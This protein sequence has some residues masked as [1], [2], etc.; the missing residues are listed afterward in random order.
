MWTRA[1]SCNTEQDR[2]GPLPTFRVSQDSCW[3]WG[4]GRQTYGSHS[5]FRQ[6]LPKPGLFTRTS[7]SVASSSLS[8]WS[9]LD[10]VRGAFTGCTCDWG[11]GMQ[12]PTC[13]STHVYGVGTV[14]RHAHKHRMRPCGGSWEAVIY[15]RTRGGLHLKQSFHLPP[16]LSFRP[17]YSWQSWVHLGAPFPRGR[18]MNFLSEGSPTT[19]STPVTVPGSRRVKASPSSSDPGAPERAEE[20]ENCWGRVHAPEEG[21]LLPIHP[22]VKGQSRIVTE[23]RDDDGEHESQTHKSGRKHNLWGDIRGTCGTTPAVSAPQSC[24]SLITGPWW[25]RS[26][27]RGT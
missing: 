4:R 5:P 22:G 10:R 23:R 14:T 17:P 18:S 9:M 27:F 6:R 1:G 15:P 8:G 25:R 24:C 26:V 3:H 16:P 2:G 13:N 19:P 7:A 20:N 11:G 21:V 12:Q